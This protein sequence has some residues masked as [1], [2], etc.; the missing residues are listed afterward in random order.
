M[1]YD[2]LVERNISIPRAKVFAM[3]TDFGGVKKI[4]P[5]AIGTC[6]CVGDG[7]GAQRTLTLADA[8]GRIV[9]RMEIAHDNAV[10]A[11]SILENDIDLE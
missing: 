1:N 3:L 5:D 7:V 6:D 11:Y 10:F 4:L 8:E 9:E 2:A